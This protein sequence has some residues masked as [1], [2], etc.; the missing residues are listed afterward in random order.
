MTVIVQGQ[1]LPVLMPLGQLSLPGHISIEILKRA[2]VVSSPGLQFT[3]VICTT[4]R[5]IHYKWRLNVVTRC[6]SIHNFTKLTFL[7]ELK[8]KRKKYGII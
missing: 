4:S 6:I 5:Q 2:S 3:F 7:T 1:L 8:L